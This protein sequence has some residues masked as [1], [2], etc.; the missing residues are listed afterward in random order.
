MS[1]QVGSDS[2]KMVPKSVRY[3]SK[4]DFAV[5][6][7]NSFFGTMKRYG[8]PLVYGFHHQILIHSTGTSKLAVMLWT[9]ELQRHLSEEGSNIIVMCAHPGAVLTGSFWMH[10]LRLLLTSVHFT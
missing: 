5:D 3:K 9:F 7:G 4:E 10:H 8:K 2:Y 1:L 6:T